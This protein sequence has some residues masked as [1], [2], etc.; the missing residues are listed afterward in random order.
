M[1]SIR[2]FKDKDPIKENIIATMKLK[3]LSIEDSIKLGSKH[4]NFQL[5]SDALA[6][7]EKMLQFILENNSESS[8]VLPLA[9]LLF[10]R[11][12]MSNRLFAVLKSHRELLK[13]ALKQPNAAK[14]CRVVLNWV[15]RQVE[16]MES[17]SIPDSWVFVYEDLLTLIDGDQTSSVYYF[18]SLLLELGLDC[19]K[20]REQIYARLIR[21]EGVR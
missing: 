6:L 9:E 12:T 11:V 1:E 15:G 10:E 7:P 14:Y 13:D 17:L 19:P 18:I 21:S 8:L 4:K 20:A 16:K 3:I 2:I 5:C